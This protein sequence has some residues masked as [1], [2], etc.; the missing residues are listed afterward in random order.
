MSNIDPCNECG[1]P[2]LESVCGSCEDPREDLPGGP[3]VLTILV[4]VIILVV[5]FFAAIEKFTN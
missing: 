1:Y 4:S 5:G 3:L 2:S